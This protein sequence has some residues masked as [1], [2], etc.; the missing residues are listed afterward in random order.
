M[1]R[2]WLEYDFWFVPC[3]SNTC[4]PLMAFCFAFSHKAKSDGALNPNPNRNIIQCSEVQ[5]RI[6]KRS[7]VWYSEV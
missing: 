7:V 2:I 1:I 5:W 3:L 4:L 6:V